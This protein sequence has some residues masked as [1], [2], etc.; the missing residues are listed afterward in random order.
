M[1][2]RLTCLYILIVM[3]PGWFS[4]ILHCQTESKALSDSDKLNEYC[5]NALNFSEL[6]RDSAIY[7]SQLA[8]E[9]AEELNQKFYRA[10]ILCDLGFTLLSNGDYANS[11]TNLLEAN[12]LVEDKNIADNVIITPFF[13]SYFTGKNPDE[14][15]LIL[16]GYIK[17]NLATLY[18]RTENYD[19]Q[20]GVL[21]EVKNSFESGK[22]DEK[23]MYSINTNIANAYFDKGELDSALYFQKL[24]LEIE[25]SFQDKDYSGASNAN[26]GK[27]LFAQG[28]Y[29][30]ARNYFLD[31]LNQLQKNT[32]QNKNIVA[33]TQFALANT[34]R[35][36]GMADSSLYYSRLGIATYRDIGSSAPEMEEAYTELALIFKEEQRFDSAFHYMYLAKSLSDSIS[37]GEI[38][39]LSNYHKLAFN[40]QIRLMETQ[41]EKD[42]LKARNQ[43]IFLLVGLGMFSLIA[44]ILY[45]SNKMKIK[46]NLLLE[47]Q[48]NQI[49]Q[50]LSE[51][52]STQSQLIQSE[53]MA[54]LGELTA[55]IAHEIQNP[56]NFVNNFAEL[57]IELADEI[58]SH[59]DTVKNEFS[60]SASKLSTNQDT[61]GDSFS[62]MGQLF[63]DI[64][65]NQEKIHEHGKRA[66]AIVKGMLQ[67]SRTS[68][69]SKEPT[70]INDLC[71]EYLRLA[72]HGYKAKDKSFNANF[73]SELDLSIPKINV[74]P[75]D[76]GRV[77]LNLL[78]NAFYAVN[79]KSKLNIPGYEPLVVVST[80]NYEDK[81]EIRV[82]D[83]GPGIPQNVIEK[84]FQPFFTTKPTGQGTG[85]GL[86]LAYD[87]VVKGHRGDLRIHNLQ[88]QIDGVH[89][90]QEEGCMFIVTLP[91]LR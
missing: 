54:S 63:I 52:K 15:R 39:T 68:S 31:G 8:L 22:A 79:E 56:L 55:G 75:Q 3:W 81:I 53:K 46:A 86:S 13:Q 77:V 43:I 5:F 89:L 9:V 40:E 90:K 38:K 37:D 76:I 41:V 19:K 30:R 51:L 61:V 50:T 7:Y 4:A 64:K 12:R 33:L 91:K 70:D 47:V 60:N 80:K 25:R 35:Q 57:N 66:A 74:I 20:L 23:L 62:E 84:I 16:L 44:F 88:A 45:R 67:H 73:E 14:N 17:N 82:K 48:K 78:N 49:E 24:A 32:I 69:I 29:E 34:Y 83:N 6:N 42:K 72:Y 87:I 36:L 11:L 2:H 28:K 27:I 21:F 1:S 18:G 85:L 59:L 58:Q 26:I 10:S 71:G 65:S